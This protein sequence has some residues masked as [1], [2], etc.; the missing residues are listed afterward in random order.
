MFLLLDNHARTYKVFG[1]RNVISRLLGSALAVTLGFIALRFVLTPVRI[2]VITHVLQPGDYGAVTLLSMTAHG[3][4]LIVSLGG[5]E[6]LLRKMPGL[7]GSLQNAYF[8]KVFLISSI[9]GLTACLGIAW[10]WGCTPWLEEVSA[11]IGPLAAIVFFLLFLHA[12]Q[13]IYFLLGRR[14]HVQARFTQLLWSDLWFLPVLLGMSAVAWNAERIVWVWIGWLLLTMSLTWQ[15]TPLARIIRDRSERVPARI[16]LTAGL[17]LLPV[18]VSDWVFRL[19]GHYALLIYS[20]A[21]TMAMYALALNVAMIGLVA[22]VPLIDLCTVELSK[23]KA[24][25]TDPASVDREIFSRG[26]R[27]ILGVSLPVVMVLVFMPHDVIGFLAGPAF[28]QAAELLPWS[29]LL[30]VLLLFNLLFARVLML[31]GASGTVG[32]G[33]MLGALSALVFCIFLVPKMGAQ[34]ALVAITGATILVDCIYAARMRVWQWLEPQS[35][36]WGVLVGGLILFGGFGWAH[37]IPGEAL[38][39]LAA[40]GFFSLAVLLLTGIFRIRD[41]F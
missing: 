1:I 19:V 18:L 30:P 28:Q 21:A 41:F 10:A 14:D 3:L 38:L 15:W 20:D 4:A 9:A 5:F 6:V 8:R 39:R 25:K 35:F 13:R 31:Q 40:M 29:G 23:S 32:F 33:S 37:L 17:P 2:N 7:E 36:G 26:F 27:Q 11:L 22:G 12:L 24:M 16:V 34:G